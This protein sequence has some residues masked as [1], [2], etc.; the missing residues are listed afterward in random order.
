MVLESLENRQ[1]LAGDVTLFS[2]SFESGSNSNDWAG[3]VMDTPFNIDLKLFVGTVAIP[4]IGVTV[5][6][7]ISVRFRGA[8]PCRFAR[9][10]PRSIFSG[11][12]VCFNVRVRNGL[13]SSAKKTHAQK[14]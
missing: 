5:F 4:S 6:D 11:A 13:R 12:A 9:G 14:S 1:L 2:D 7:R 3:Y 8:W 10:L